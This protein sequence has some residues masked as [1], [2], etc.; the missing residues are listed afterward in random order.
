[1]KIEPSLDQIERRIVTGMI[2]S[3]NYLDEIIGIFRPEFLQSDEG[4]TIAQWCLDYH[5]KYNDAPGKHIKDV[6]ASKK[7]DGLPSQTI[8]MLELLIE[9][10]S[11]DYNPKQFNM[12]FILAESEKYFRQRDLAILGEDLQDLSRAGE[13]LEA[14]KRLSTH[15]L[16]ARNSSGAITVTDPDEVTIRQ[17][18]NDSRESLIQYPGAMGRFVND[19][20][21]REALVGIMGP[22]KVGKT[23]LMLDMGIRALR[24]GSNVAFF[25]A[26]DMSENQLLR[27]IG[28]HQCKRSDL[29]KFCKPM[30]VPVMDCARNQIGACD[31]DFCR[32]DD[33]AP[34]AGET[35]NILATKSF[36]DL[37]FAAREYPNHDV[38]SVCVKKGLP[39]YGALWLRYQDEVEPITW[40]EAHDAMIKLGRLTRRR[41]KLYCYPNDTLRIEDVEAELDV[42][43][44]REDWIPD[45]VVIDYADIMR[46]DGRDERDKQN[47]LWKRLRSLS[48]KRKCLV[49]T[50]TQAS[51]KSYDQKSLKRSHFSEDKRKYAHVTAMLGIQQDDDEKRKGILRLNRLVVRE[52]YFEEGSCVHILQR[53]EMGRPFLGSY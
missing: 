20:L 3:K 15:S 1:M 31:L 51:A 40:K 10:L 32:G 22:E 23:F 33:A 13:V 42:L 19:E 53:L 50:A 14:E 4:R 47:T 16:L 52:D 7:Q 27:R 28:I 18:F 21:T 9:S 44:R 30:W 26:G 43:T 2:V 6:L 41:F 11:G 49:L 37:K 5:S 24:S 17:A 35:A 46:M 34:F 8:T 12:E 39:F 48:Q 25:E 29:D 38:C 36:S 45:V